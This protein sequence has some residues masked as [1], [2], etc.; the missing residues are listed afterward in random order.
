M[1]EFLKLTS[2]EEALSKLLENLTSLTLTK[3]IIPTE[4]AL[5]RVL[6]KDIYSPES[7]PSFQRS[8][9]DGYAVIASDTYGA[10]ESLPGYLRVVGEVSM[11]RKSEIPVLPGQAMVIHTGGMLPD[12]SD[13]VVMLENTQIPK[14]GEV[15]ILRSVAPLENVILAGED[16][17]TGDLILNV[18]IR[19][20]PAEIGGLMA[21][22]LTEIP[23]FKI[24]RIGVISTGDEVVSPEN[25]IL[26]GQVRDANS[27]SLSALIKQAGGFPVQYGIIPDWKEALFETVKAALKNCDMVIVTAGSSASTR[28]Y[29]AEVIQAQ[30][31]PGV[32]VHGINIRPGKPT[33]FGVCKNK[34]VIGLPGNPVSALVIARL[35]VVPAIEKISGL[36]IKTIYPRLRLVIT[37]N[38]PSQAGREDWVPVQ[39]KLEGKEY[40]A[41]PIF[42]KS[43]LIFALIRADGLA[44]IPPEVT[45][46]QA[47]ETVEVI[48]I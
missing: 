17:K 16:L 8:S 28:D 35:F 46:V 41:T 21:L 32:L 43:N 4:D 25:N 1:S 7:L 9:V 13:A 47:G 11:G 44:R 30:G 23:V 15:E 31:L 36:Q 5:G 22:G 20:R 29:T 18:G 45:G 42:F 10:T 40:S 48:L 12:G 39:I 24:P 3:E 26:P 19:I 37:S 34:P 14:D 33:I 27:Y 38:V 2:P 6:A